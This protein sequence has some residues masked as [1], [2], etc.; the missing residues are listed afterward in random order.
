VLD[1]ENC[2]V[3]GRFCDVEA[4]SAELHLILS[5]LISS[6]LSP[7]RSDPVYRGCDQPDRTARPA[8]FCLVA[9]VVDWVASQCTLTAC[10]QIGNV[11]IGTLSLDRR[12]RCNEKKV[13]GAEAWRGKVCGCCTSK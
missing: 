13:T 6:E 11:T 4:S 7:P 8:S 9:I 5:D 10:T 3:Y 1:Q 2:S 12:W